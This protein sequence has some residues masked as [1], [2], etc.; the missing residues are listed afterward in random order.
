MSNE[1]VILEVKGLKMEFPG[2]SIFGRTTSSFKAVRDISFDIKR[3]ETLGL[4]GGNGCGK[5]T[6]SR[7]ILQLY[8]PTAGTLIFKGL[9]LS[10]Q[11]SAEMKKIRRNMQ[12][13]LDGSCQSLNPRMH[14]GELIAEPILV[15]KLDMNAEERRARVADMLSLVQLEPEMAEHY[16]VEFSAEQQMR[17]EI[18]RAM[19][20]KPEFIICDD[21]A[22]S[23]DIS[24]RERIIHLLKWFRD[25]RKLTYLFMSRDI[26]ITRHLCDRVMIM[27]A[28]KI[29][30]AAETKE[31]FNHP[32]HPYTIEMMSG[33]DVSETADSLSKRKGLKL[34]NTRLMN[35]NNGCSFRYNCEKSE[36]I[37]REYE[38]EIKDTGNGHMVACHRI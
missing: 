18:A 33:L 32:L 26:A 10:E 30:E 3:G 8:K 5:T 25:W 24:V 13:I 17:I 34:K 6:V 2:G 19:I 29:V 14:I 7:C 21:P 36:N 16:P 11:N 31:L 15:H 38:P 37:C 4:I 23:L 35:I 9:N 20:L 12:I 22:S 1:E 28:G 27:H